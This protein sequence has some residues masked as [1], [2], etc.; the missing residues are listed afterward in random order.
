[1]PANMRIS[2][3]YWQ[4]FKHVTNRAVWVQMKFTLLFVAGAQLRT[5]AV[6]GKNLERGN[7]IL[8]L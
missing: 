6:L 4:L 8:E 2:D 3:W 7:P 1:M 5:F